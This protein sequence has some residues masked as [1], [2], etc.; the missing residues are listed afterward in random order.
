MAHK[1]I[2]VFEYLLLSFFFIGCDDPTFPKEDANGYKPVYSANEPITF[3]L[4]VPIQNPDKV[5]RFKNYLLIHDSKKGV[6]VIDN[7]DPTAPL[8][9]GFIR[10]PD[11]TDM[12]IKDS[13]LV[14][15][16]RN[17]LVSLNLAATITKINEVSRL[18][19]WKI[20]APPY[21]SKYF[22]CV[23]TTKEVVGW[24]EARLPNATCYR[25]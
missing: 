5:L 14:V 6:H 9:I 18:K 13:I 16:H 17:N 25:Q 21:H 22:E 10:V 11:N 1:I 2:K 19:V 4:S 7:T 3:E 8:S 12:V 23:D 15:D 24:V 20:T